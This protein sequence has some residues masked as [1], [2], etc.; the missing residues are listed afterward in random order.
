MS[1]LIKIESSSSDLKTDSNSLTQD[2]NVNQVETVRDDK[3]TD[4]TEGGDKVPVKTSSAGRL[5]VREYGDIKISAMNLNYVFDT[6]TNFDKPKL[7]GCFS[8]QLNEDGNS[9]TYHGDKSSL[10]YCCFDRFEDYIDIDLLE[11]Y[12]RTTLIGR[13]PVTEIHVLRWIIDNSESLAEN[14]ETGSIADFIFHSRVIRSIMATPFI[15]KDDW[16]L[17][18]VKVRGSIILAEMDTEQRRNDVSYQ[19]EDRLKGSYAGYK[20]LEKLTRYPDGSRASTAFNGA[21]DSFYTVTRSKVGGH[22]LLYSN[23]VDCIVDENQFEKPLEQMKFAQIKTRGHNWNDNKNTRRRFYQ[24]RI[25]GWWTE[26][27]ISGIDT[28]ICG[29]KRPN[30]TV[31]KVS[32]IQAN[33]LLQRSNQWSPS[34]CVQFLEKTLT[35]IKEM[36]TEELTVYKIICDPHTGIKARKLSDPVDK[37]IPSWYINGQSPNDQ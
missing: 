24:N 35:F 29:D 31:Q 37:H 28:I 8:C 4:L 11:S 26:A 36:V 19:I 15:P 9:E 10:R 14:Q 32:Q 5:V 17:I 7:I 21:R 2:D 13:V 27:L 25:I 34:T 12:S 30:N 1:E 6:Y 23:R 22:T 18:A 3:V 16:T 20:F 33:S